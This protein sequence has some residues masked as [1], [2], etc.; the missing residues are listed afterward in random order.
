MNVTSDSVRDALALVGCHLRDDR[1]G[2]DVI[3]ANAADLGEVAEVLAWAVAGPLRTVSP[4]CR[5]GDPQQLLARL[6]EGLA[7]D[8]GA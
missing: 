5:D 6:R 2:A 8:G 3:K 1:E 7:G 4:A